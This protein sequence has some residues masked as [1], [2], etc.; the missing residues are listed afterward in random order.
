MKRRTFLKT[1]GASALGL[2]GL[3]GVVR[4]SLRQ[5][6]ISKRKP[7]YIVVTMD[8][9]R[10][11]HLGCY[12]YHRNT[13]PNLD[14]FADESIVFEDAYGTSHGTL[15][16]H[17]SIF[18]GLYPYNHGVLSNKRIIPPGIPNLG[19]WLR[20][21]GYETIGVT[22]TSFLNK[23]TTGNCFKTV[24]NSQEY[25]RRSEYTID[26]AISVLDWLNTRKNP[27]FLWVHLWDPHFQ[28]NPPKEFKGKFFKEEGSERVIQFLTQKV[29]DPA[30][31]FERLSLLRLTE[32]EQ[33]VI[34]GRYDEEI[35]YMDSQIGR[36]LHE[37]KKENYM[38]VQL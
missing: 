3:A 12:G 13:S 10:K 33:E 35:A 23:Q 22:S 31:Q 6:H 34:K 11:D 26:E 16:N 28:Y 15:P 17:N 20:E 2:A 24:F 32:L 25:E 1:A 18:T 7:N 5:P 14:K 21:Q 4:N 36:F 9:T 38:I 37:L 19:D 29:E 27:F 8:T 30:E